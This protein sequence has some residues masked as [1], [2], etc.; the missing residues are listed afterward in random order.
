MKWNGLETK[1]WYQKNW[2]IEQNNIKRLLDHFNQSVV[3]KKSKNY[4]WPGLR[5]VYIQL[6]WAINLHRKVI[7]TWFW[8]QKMYFHEY[9]QNKTLWNHF[10]HCKTLKN[11][12]NLILSQLWLVR[13]LF[14]TARFS[15]NYEISVQKLFFCI[16]VCPY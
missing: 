7:E 2:L 6:Y 4:F 12:K 5:T 15:T 14:L 11:P 1:I 16:L 8:Y 9:N 13:D 10:D 3:V